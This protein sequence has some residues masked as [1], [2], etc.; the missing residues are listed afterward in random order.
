MRDLGLSFMFLCWLHHNSR[1][2]SGS[3]AFN[4]SFFDIRN[5]LTVSSTIFLEEPTASGGP[6]L[7]REGIFAEGRPFHQ[8]KVLF[9]IELDSLFAFDI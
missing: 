9:E 5:F 4:S 3:V 2:L 6:N 8:A 7:I 1:C